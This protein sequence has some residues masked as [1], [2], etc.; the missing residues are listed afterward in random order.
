MR[1]YDVESG[2][3]KIDGTN[4]KSFNINWLRSKIGLVSQEPIL[5]NTSILENISYGELNKVHTMD[6]IIEATSFSN[7]HN[8]IE[9]LS[10]VILLN[11]FF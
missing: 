9:S 3:I 2:E 7:I 11:F 8:K 1:F 5:F 4:I 10:N 6:D